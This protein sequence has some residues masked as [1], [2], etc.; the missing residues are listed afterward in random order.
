MIMHSNDF[1]AAFSNFLDRHEY[2]EAENYLFS[3]VRLAFA[4]GWK[5]AG[6]APPQQERIFELLPNCSKQTAPTE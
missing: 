1:E 4:A 3:M 2:D 6:G 5:A